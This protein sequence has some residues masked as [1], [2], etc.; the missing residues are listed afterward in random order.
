MRGV[1]QLGPRRQTIGFDDSG[2][3]R[4]GLHAERVAHRAR[5]DFELVFVH[6]GERDEHHE[7]A[8]HQTHEVGKGHEPTVAS[9]MRIAA[10]FLGHRLFPG[11]PLPAD[12]AGTGSP[13]SWRCFS[14]RYASSISRTSV[15]L[16]ES[17]IIRMPSM[18]SVRLVSSSS[19]LPC[20]LSASGRQNRFATS[21]P[22]NVANSA[23]AMNGPSLEGSVMLAN[24]CTMPIS[25]PIMPNAGAQSP[26]AR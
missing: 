11:P 7:E 25:V 24:I 26:M 21:A 6:G 20:S 19:S 23:V 13:S 5:D 9:S 2:I 16:L 4:L 10:F 8:H 15:G 3:A 1:L 12:Q 14:G 17:R 22:Y 18:I